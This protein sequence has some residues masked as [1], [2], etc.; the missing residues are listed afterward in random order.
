VQYKSEFGR[1][2]RSVTELGPSAANLIP[3]DLAA[4]EKRGYKFTLMPM[5]GGYSIQAVPAAFG[6]TG[7]RTFYT[8][9]SLI[10]RQNFGSEPAAT[11]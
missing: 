7:S 5:A 6:V 10:V 2:A 11:W 1:Y 8:D 9:Q 4:G 3:A